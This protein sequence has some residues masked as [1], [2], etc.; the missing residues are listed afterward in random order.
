MILT[1]LLFFCSAIILLFLV[2][3]IMGGPSGVGNNVPAK[4][5]VSSSEQI[6]I[7]NGKLI[8]RDET[9]M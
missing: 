3:L 6:S 4:G 7:I 1:T 9:K 8:P 5:A 2:N